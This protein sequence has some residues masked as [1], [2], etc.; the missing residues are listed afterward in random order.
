MFTGIVQGLGRVESITISGN[1]AR[2]KIH[3]GALAARVSS[4]DSVSVSGVCLTATSIERE[5]VAFD[6]VATTLSKTRLGRLKRGDK[7]NLELALKLGDPLGGHLV[8]GHV[9]GLGTI[10]AVDRQPGEVRI[11]IE[12]PSEVMDYLVVRGSVAL[13]GI[14]LTV[15]KL[16]SNGFEVAVIPFTLK[17]TTLVEA[18]AGDPVNLEGDMIGRWVAKYVNRVEGGEGSTIEKLREEGY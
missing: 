14:S 6:A 13:D 3:C 5:E 11:R 1:K 16:L 2:I 17:E 10:R 12:A 7:V 15:A 4:G 18:K 9:D 8:Y